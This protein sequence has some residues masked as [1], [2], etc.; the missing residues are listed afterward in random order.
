[1][2]K[3]IIQIVKKIV[4]SSFLLYGYNI[5]V[6]PLGLIIP[7]NLITVGFISIFGLPALFSLILIH[8]LVF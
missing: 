8:V 4:F 7:I 2:I 5:L 3:T 1:M 6:E